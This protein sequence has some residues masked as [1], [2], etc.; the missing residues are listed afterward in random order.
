M[1]C[2]FCKKTFSSISAKHVHQQSTK[3]CLKIQEE[4]GAKINKTSFSCDFCSREFTIKSSFIRHNLVCNKKRENSIRA[5]EERLNRIEEKTLKESTPQQL[6]PNL[7]LEKKDVNEFKFGPDLFVPI[8][9]DGFINATDLCKAGNKILSQ[10]LENKHTKE[11]LEVL[12]SDLRIP[13]N[14]LIQHQAS[15]TWVHRKVGYHIAQWISTKFAISLFNSIDE[16]FISGKVMLN[17]QKSYNDIE[18]MYQ[19]KI[20]ELQLQLDQKEQLQLKL[21]EKEKQVMLQKEEY[22]KLLV[23]HVSSLKKHRYVKFNE[24]GPCFYII[25]QGTPCECHHNQF[26]YKFGIAGMSEDGDSIDDRLKNHRT[27]WPQLK[28]LYLLFIKEADVIEKSIKRVY[29]EAINPS[30]HEIIVGIPI[31]KLI[32]SIN[33]IISVLGITNFH[34]MTDDKIKAYN[35][36]VVTTIKVDAK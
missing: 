19:Q 20:K 23:K 14:E 6:S 11:F 1:D 16:L 17:N 26:R 30:G 2:E 28:V 9:K 24:K 35:N 12:E 8:R 10:Y 33:D 29:D 27:N 4:K 18:I 22:Q 32:S 13:I 5:M 15:V 34:L 3:S 21:E 31:D 36:Y 25:E 7:V